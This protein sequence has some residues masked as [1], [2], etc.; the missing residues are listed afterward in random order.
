MAGLTH[1]PSLETPKNF[2]GFDFDNKTSV[3]IQLDR[4]LIVGL[5]LLD[6][7]IPVSF[8]IPPINNYII[9]FLI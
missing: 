8:K 2:S 7:Y 6:L 9:F 3:K 1:F 4:Q 5:V